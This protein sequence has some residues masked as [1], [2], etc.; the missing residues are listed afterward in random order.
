MNIYKDKIINYLIFFFLIYFCVSY[1]FKLEYV[2]S[3]RDEISYLSDSLLLLEGITPVHSYAP[4][5]ISTWFGSLFVLID[6]LIN[7]ISLTSTEKLFDS[8]D[9]N[10]FKHYQNLIYIKSSLFFLNSILLIYFFFLDKKKIF[11]LL[12]FIFLLLPQINLETFS[13]TPYFTACIFCAISFTLKDKNKLLS[14]IFFGLA[15]SERIEFI[16][17]INF[18]ILDY[19][20]IKL[21][22]Y[23]IIFITF[24]VASPWFSITFLANIKT[25]VSVFY[26]MSGNNTEPTLVILLTKI[27]L[28]LFIVIIFIYSFS[29][30][31]KIKTFYLLLLSL[32]T[33][34]F[35]F[36]G[37]V[38]MRWLLP[39]FLVLS[40]EISL[41]IN[42]NLFINKTEDVPKI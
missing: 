37:T 11:L 41:L 3:T 22:N 4:A 19:N 30:N 10:L 15:L 29:D 20:K 5:G 34:N 40:Y 1:F 8:F 27:S 38:G 7:K 2:L 21:K 28:I 18:V 42:K 36:S 35:Y 25:I 33:V 26:N 24:M 13:G 31:K 16:L 39:V 23:F 14:L 9:A 32:M 12:L 6:F 17:L